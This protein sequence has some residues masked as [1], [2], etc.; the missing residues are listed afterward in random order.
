MT[1]VRGCIGVKM[2]IDYIHRCSTCNLSSLLLFCLSYL[3]CIAS[4]LTFNPP[5]PLHG[6]CAS[7]FACTSLSHSF[8][9]LSSYLFHPSP[10]N[11]FTLGLLS[12]SFHLS[13]YKP[14]AP[15]FDA[16]Y[17]DKDTTTDEW[18]R[19]DCVAF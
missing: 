8:P 12:F 15:A 2:C 14:E 13:L 17:E 7:L 16:S 11:P 10:I 19:E 18:K 4:L 9:S 6:T 5:L 1:Y 3:L